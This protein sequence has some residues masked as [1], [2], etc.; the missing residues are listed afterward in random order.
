MVTRALL[1]L[2]AALTTGCSHHRFVAAPDEAAR[3]AQEAAV[4]EIS[5]SVPVAE[6]ESGTF[7]SPEGA[8]IP[9][10][11][12]RPRPIEPDRTYPLVVI[13]HGSGAIGTDNVSQ[14]GPLAKS[15]ATPAM[16]ERHPAFVLVPQFSGRSAV[17]RDAGTPNATSSATNLLRA[18]LMLI[19]EMVRTLP[20]DEQRVSAIGFSMG[21]SAVWNA[22]VL[23]PELFASAAIV[24]GVPNP[25]ALHRSSTRLLLVHGDA[26][27]ENPFSAALR[28]YE[29]AGSRRIEFRQYRGLAHDFPPDLIA[30]DALKE[31]LLR[32]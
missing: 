6:F 8:V 16:R 20:V 9:Y 14:I 1:A 5:R 27:E 18:A 24:A 19:D 30:T 25:E 15:W 10:R 11:L 2:L 4:A 32:R 21:G 31:W 28:A 12:L 3:A 17:Y 22:L 13:F 23:R 29:Q 7:T 26:D